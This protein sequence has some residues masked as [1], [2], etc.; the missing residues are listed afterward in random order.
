MVTYIQGGKHS[1]NLLLIDFTPGKTSWKIESSKISV[2]LNLSN[3]IPSVNYS[4]TPG[5]L[6]ENSWNIVFK[7]G[8]PPCYRTINILF[9]VKISR[10]YYNAKSYFLTEHKENLQEIPCEEWE[11]IKLIHVFHISCSITIRSILKGIYFLY[12]W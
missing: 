11:I 8:W 1:W 3:H 6:L 2:T 5:I 4:N 12:F 9:S 7:F 10:H